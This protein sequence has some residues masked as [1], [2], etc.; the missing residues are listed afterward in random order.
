MAFEISAIRFSLGCTGFHKRHLKMPIGF[1][2]SACSPRSGRVTV[3]QHF[4]VGKHHKASEVRAADDEQQAISDC[5]NFASFSRPFHGLKRENRRFPS[6][7]VLG[8]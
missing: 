3:A 1:A 8:Y 7:E 6:T 5:F 4:S 2:Q